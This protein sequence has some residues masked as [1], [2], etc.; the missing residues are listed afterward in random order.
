MSD[1]HL[2][3][4]PHDIG[5]RNDAWWYEESMGVNV[6]VEPQDRTTQIMIPWRA[7][8]AALARKER[9]DE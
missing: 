1:K 4:K 9:G 5:S 3:L 7:I 8:K 2:I 6:I